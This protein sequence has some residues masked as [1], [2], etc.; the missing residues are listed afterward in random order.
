MGI[1]PQS[2]ASAS[3]GRRSRVPVAFF[4]YP[5]KPS[6]LAP[7]DC[8]VEALAT[9]AEDLLDALQRLAQEVG[10]DRG[11]FEI[12]RASPAPLPRGALNAD[13]IG[14]ALGSLIPENAIVIDESVSTGRNFFP[15]THAAAPHDWLQLTGG[16]IGEGIPLAIGAAVACP[17]RKVIALQADGSAMYTVQGLWTQ[18]RENLDVL[19]LI[20]SNRTYQILRGELAN[21]GAKNPGP[22]ALQMLSLADPDLDWPSLA[23][24]MGVDAT[25]VDTIDDLISTFRSAVGR[26]GPYLIEVCL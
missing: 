21:V 6:R 1:R 3:A 19:T 25:R 13:A 7:E 10:A 24:G 23:K 17:D 8:R 4:A 5:D 26:R 15:A 2:S 16:A 12:P 9:P 11:P 14:L 22:K 20:W 18:A